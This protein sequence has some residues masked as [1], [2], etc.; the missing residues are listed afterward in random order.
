[1]TVFDDDHLAETPIERSALYWKNSAKMY[2]QAC[3]AESPEVKALFIQIAMAWATLADELE[4]AHTEV[5][6]E[7]F[8]RRSTH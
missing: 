4:R 7:A 1:M 8:E 5:S 2:G 6:R 3:S